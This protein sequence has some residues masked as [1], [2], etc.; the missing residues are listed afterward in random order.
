VRFFQ[1][2]STIFR[3][4]KTEQFRDIVRRLQRRIN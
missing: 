2:N 3:T 1:N 4:E